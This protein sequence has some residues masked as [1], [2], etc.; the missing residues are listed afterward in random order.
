VGSSTQTITRSEV[1]VMT[2]KLKQAAR[3]LGDRVR[4]PGDRPPWTGAAV[5]AC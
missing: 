1:I 4:G 5:P 2:R 3:E